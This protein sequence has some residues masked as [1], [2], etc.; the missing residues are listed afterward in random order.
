MELSAFA[1][2]YRPI[3]LTFVGGRATPWGREL[4]RRAHVL[5]DV[6][7]AVRRI[8]ERGPHGTHAADLQH[9]S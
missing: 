6:P 7:R 1:M 8:T 4:A 9:L 2:R 5:D 3:V